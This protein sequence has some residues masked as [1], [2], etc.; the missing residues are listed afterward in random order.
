MP[1]LL[2]AP[3]PLGMQVTVCHAASPPAAP[4]NNHGLGTLPRLI[5]AAGNKEVGVFGL[6]LH[7][8]GLLAIPSFYR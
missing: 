4:G 3:L 6:R 8:A 5:G 1:L 7:T 2:I